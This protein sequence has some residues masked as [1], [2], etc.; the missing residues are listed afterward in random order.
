MG[1][2]GA[3]ADDGFLIDGGVVFGV[4]KIGMEQIIAPDAAGIFAVA[5]GEDIPFLPLPAVIGFG[6]DVIALRRG[7]SAGAAG[8]DHLAHHRAVGGAVNGD[9]IIIAVH[10]DG[11]GRFLAQGGK[12]QKQQ[13]QQKCQSFECAH[14]VSSE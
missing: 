8:A 1:G 10:V 11:V 2:V 13:N 9:D 14:R 12:G 5:L 6:H 7:G 4:K 3:H